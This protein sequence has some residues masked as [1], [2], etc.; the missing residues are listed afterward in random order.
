MERFLPSSFSRCVKCA[1]KLSACI[2]EWS[3]SFVASIMN[4]MEHTSVTRAH[5]ISG[6]ASSSHAL[7]PS[8]SGSATP[9][10]YLGECKNQSGFRTG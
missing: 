9:D 3:P 1:A 5:L 10:P 8:L 2:A 4:N 6:G 7:S